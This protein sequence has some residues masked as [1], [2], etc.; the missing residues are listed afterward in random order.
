VVGIVADKRLRALEA[1][2]RLRRIGKEDKRDPIVSAEENLK[3]DTG[4]GG[5]TIKTLSDDEEVVCRLF[6]Q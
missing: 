5:N 3:R 1:T 4:Y 6:C 2:F